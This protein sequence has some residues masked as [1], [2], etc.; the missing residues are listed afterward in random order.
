MQRRILLG[1]FSLS[2]DAM[3]NYFIQAQRVRRLIQQE[4]NTVFA[5]GHP[6]AAARGP[7]TTRADAA[8]VDVIVCPTAPSAPPRLADVSPG[9]SSSPL[10]AYVN[11]VFTV[12]ASLAGLP[13]VSVPV[14]VSESEQNP[15]ADEL[16]GIQVIGQYGDDELVMKVGELLEGKRLDG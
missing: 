10:D 16:A 3:D 5:A 12:P 6:L 9:S 8:D 7:E 13:A 11:D 2:A 14:T 15:D 4:F 1:T